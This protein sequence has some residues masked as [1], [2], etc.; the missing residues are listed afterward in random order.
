MSPAVRLHEVRVVQEVP[1]HDVDPLGVVWHGHYFK[2]FELA[3]TEL[4]RRVGLDAGELIGRQYRFLITESQCRHIHPLKYA[5]KFEVAAWIEDFKNR[6]HIAYE[7]SSLD[8]PRRSTEGRTILVTTD[9]EG[10]LLL[11]TPRAILD[12]I[13]GDAG[14]PA[15]PQ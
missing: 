5:E 4:L 13:G 9:A 7:I 14:L 10:R 6:L 2:Y 3:R 8:N 1:F 11:R 12:R 15:P